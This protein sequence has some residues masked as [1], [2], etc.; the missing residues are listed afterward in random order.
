MTIN[1]IQQI[2]FKNLVIT[3]L[4][5]K[6]KIISIGAYR[7]IVHNHT[8]IYKLKVGESDLSPRKYKS[9]DNSIIFVELVGYANVDYTLYIYEEDTQSYRIKK[10]CV[11]G[12]NLFL[13]TT[14]NF[15]KVQRF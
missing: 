14:T 8:I 1:D 5:H 12:V 3:S 4:S 13:N 11:M 15:E 10:N 2:D 7:Y 6:R 9:N